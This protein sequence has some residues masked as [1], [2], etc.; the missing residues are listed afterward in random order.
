MPSAAKISAGPGAGGTKRKSTTPS[1]Q[2]FRLVLGAGGMVGIAY[3]AGVMRALAHDLGL[4]PNDASLVVGTSAGSVVG[5]YIRVGTSMEDLWTLAIGTHPSLEGLGS[6]PEERRKSMALVPSFG[7]GLDLPRRLV[8]SYWVTL[9]SFVP[10]PLPRIPVAI[11]KTFRAGLF[12]MRAARE[13]LSADLG[14]AWPE[15]PLAICGVDLADGQRTVFSA[16][17]EVSAT[18]TEA[19]AASCAVPGLYVPVR[20]GSRVFVDGGVHSST[21]LDVA[22]RH[23]GQPIIC[24][25]PMDYASEDDEGVVHEPDVL[26]RLARRLP[27][28]Q[29]LRELASAARAGTKVVLIR[30]THTEVREHGINLMRA[31]GGELV[32]ERAYETTKNSRALDE[33]ANALAV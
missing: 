4:T 14:E 28:Q 33:I 7:G 22:V 19:V 1:A 9:R 31:T 6:S 21:N 32:A 8:G 27:H 25:A 2:S 10:L 20:V 11:Q 23:D 17:S 29:L 24:V 30:P 26:A 18:L 5:A 15:K 12:T 3:H 16:A 13:R